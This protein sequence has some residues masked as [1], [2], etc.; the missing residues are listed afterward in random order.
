[1]CSLSQR[2]G[3]PDTDLGVF[4]RIAVGAVTADKDD[5]SGISSA[6]EAVRTLRHSDDALIYPRVAINALIVYGKRAGPDAGNQNEL[7]RIEN[8]ATV[9][10]SRTRVPKE[11]AG[12]TVERKNV[13]T[14]NRGHS[15]ANV[16]TH[17]RRDRQARVSRHPWI[18]GSARGVQV[19][20]RINVTAR[21]A[22][23]A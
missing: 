12:P 20:A 22:L 14:F 18:A 2:L 13:R 7:N 17:C 16:E 9:A 8:T 19:V 23:G 6:L 11:G 15:T 3:E 1:M 10:G 21:V 5:F 4:V